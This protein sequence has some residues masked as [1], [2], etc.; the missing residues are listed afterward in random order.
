MKAQAK[1]PRCGGEKG[2]VDRG[3]IFCHVCRNWFA[4]VTDRFDA[5]KEVADYKKGKK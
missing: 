4:A 5:K 2:V 1:C 3:L